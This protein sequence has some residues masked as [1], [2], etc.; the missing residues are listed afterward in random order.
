MYFYDR[1]FFNEH[2]IVVS[3]PGRMTDILEA[4]P[5]HHEYIYQRPDRRGSTSDIAHGGDLH[6]S[7]FELAPASAVIAFDSTFE[8]SES[9]ENLRINQA[10]PSG[11]APLV[12]Q[13]ITYSIEHPDFCLDKQL[14][15]RRSALVGSIL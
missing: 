15:D 10:I 14:F 12:R 3:R 6:S 1:L 4:L 8:D 11:L 5:Q 9:L 7:E 2:F 13:V